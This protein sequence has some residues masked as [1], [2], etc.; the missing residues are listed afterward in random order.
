MAMERRFL[1]AH[2]AHGRAAKMRRPAAAGEHGSHPLKRPAGASGVP[3]ATA[4]K[5]MRVRLRLRG[6]QP[7]V[8]PCTI[9]DELIR[10]KVMIRPL[11]IRGKGH[12]GSED[13][14]QLCFARPGA[15]YV[16]R[17]IFAYSSF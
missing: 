1:T 14:E 8:E 15:D 11:P 3:L 6:K 5:A 7:M 2:V 4:V 12:W 17:A 9:P 16:G 10:E 13:P